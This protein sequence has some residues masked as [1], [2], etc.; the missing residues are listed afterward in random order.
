MNNHGGKR[1]NSGRKKRPE[2]ELFNF[3]IEN[4]TAELL[5]P[6]NK[7]KIK[8]K[9]GKTLNAV[10][11]EHFTHLANNVFFISPNVFIDLSI[12]NSQTFNF[13]IQ[14]IKKEFIKQQQDK[15][16]ER[17]GKSLNLILNELLISILYNL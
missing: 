8:K 13:K 4:K 5:T 7:A 14:K 10:I 6:S 12:E 11:I 17:S 9:Y 1:K 3:R 15:I 16:E 2:A